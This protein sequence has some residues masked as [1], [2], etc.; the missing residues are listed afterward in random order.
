MFHIEDEKGHIISQVNETNSISMLA[1]E[2]AK[3]IDS[4]VHWV[5]T[6]L[7]CLIALVRCGIEIRLFNVLVFILWL[8][9]YKPRTVF[10]IKIY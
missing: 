6:L 4:G 10:I 5:Y 7:I 3:R 2:T 8:T 9:K 1:G